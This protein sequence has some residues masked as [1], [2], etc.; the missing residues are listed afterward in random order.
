M[1]S[2]TFSEIVRIR[3]R[4]FFLR[5][6]ATWRQLFPWALTLA[7]GLPLLMLVLHAIDPGTPLPFIVLPALAGG[8]MPV[9]MMGPGR[10][11]MRTRL[12]ANNLLG[13]LDDAL[14]SLGYRRTASDAG[15]LSYF[16]PKPWLRGREGAIV[17]AVKPHALQVVGPVGSL[18]LLQ[19]R[20]GA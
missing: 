3:E 9:A 13:T 20:I 19:Q 14:V 4:P 7:V 18:R 8:L 10:F 1:K 16:R 6:P 11:E 12:D 17:V 5:R 15:S 2:V